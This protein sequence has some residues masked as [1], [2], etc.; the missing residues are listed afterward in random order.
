MRPKLTDNILA[1]GY[2]ILLHIVLIG[3]FIIGMDGDST[4]ILV[5]PP[6]VDIV[7]ATVMDEAKILDEMTRQKYLMK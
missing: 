3:L 2:S 5:A 6:K 4:P 1:S 7:Q